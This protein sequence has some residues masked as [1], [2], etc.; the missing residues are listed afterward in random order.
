MDTLNTNYKRIQDLP[1]FFSVEVLAQVMG[2][3]LANAYDLCHRKGFPSIFVGRR[4]VVSRDEF[5]NWLQNQTRK[6]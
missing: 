4:I 1:L 6:K 3:G 2:I 5:E